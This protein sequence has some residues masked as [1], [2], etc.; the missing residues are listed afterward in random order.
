LEFVK[1]RFNDAWLVKPQKHC[2]SRGFFLE[3]Y[4]LKD[5]KSAGINVAF[6]QDNHS[7]SVEK[8]VLRGLHF[9]RPPFT[10]SKLIRAV[11]GAIFDA[12]V[13]MRKNSPTYL[14]WQGF[15]LTEGSAEMLFV[16]Q[17]FAHGF[18]TLS[19]HTEVIY[20]VDN[21]YAPEHDGGIRWND[22]DIG[23]TWPVDLP[24]LSGKDSILPF[25]KDSESPF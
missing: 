7:M 19:P 24:V 15:E 5:F 1:T 12:I 8:G 22:P 23:I 17:G 18:C 11:K 13:D 10:Q 4:T 20:K 16:P 21:Y 3:S 14:K 25:I 9:Q 2:D 6:I